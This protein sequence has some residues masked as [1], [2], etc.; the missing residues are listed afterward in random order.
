MQV[1]E[2]IGDV[3]KN[4]SKT[5]DSDQGTS[6]NQDTLFQNSLSDSVGQ[7]S[8]QSQHSSVM[9]L[10]SSLQGDPLE[11]TSMQNPSEHSAPRSSAADSDDEPLSPRSS[12]KSPSVKSSQSTPAN[13]PR[14]RNSSPGGSQVPDQGSNSTQTAQNGN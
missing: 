1:D 5:I 6:S 2:D 7:T 10:D 11:L 13:T 14:N 9:S 3:L 4:T 12:S 8:A